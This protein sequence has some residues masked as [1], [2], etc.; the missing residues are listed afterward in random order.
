M[1]N[2]YHTK[3]KKKLLVDFVFVLGILWHTFEILVIFGLA[4]SWQEKGRICHGLHLTTNHHPPIDKQTHKHLEKSVFIKKEKKIRTITKCLK[5]TLKKE[6]FF[7]NFQNN[8][9]FLENCIKMGDFF[10]R[11]KCKIITKPL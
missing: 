5:I 3:D 6:T 4:H 2:T 8:L 1:Y 7:G 9:K 11:K 10:H